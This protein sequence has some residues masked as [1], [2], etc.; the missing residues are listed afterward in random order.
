MFVRP[1]ITAAIVAIFLVLS[2]D[3]P[4]GPIAAETALPLLKSTEPDSICLMPRYTE[5]AGQVSGAG[6]LPGQEPTGALGLPPDWPGRDVVGG[7][8][9]PTRIVTDPYPTFD[10]LAVD[11]VNDVVVMSDE[12]RSGLFI[13]DRKSGSHSPAITEPKRHI[14]GPRTDLGF[15]AGVTLDAKRREAWVVNNDGGGVSVFSY[16]HH[17]DVKP[18]REL[19][20]PHQSWGLSLDATREELAVT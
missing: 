20:V 18:L 10:G 11:P 9:P 19:D 14:I 6:H 8:V 17:G 4:S 7:D 13:Y 3:R 15:I 1:L 16:D 5:G 2:S 12:N